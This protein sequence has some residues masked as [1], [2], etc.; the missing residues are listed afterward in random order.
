MIFCGH[1]HQATSVEKHGIR[2]YNVWV[3]PSPACITRD[4][5]GVNIRGYE[6][7]AEEEFAFGR[8]GDSDQELEVALEAV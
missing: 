2:Y 5:A 6:P 3:H 1:T 8:S 4:S 7:G